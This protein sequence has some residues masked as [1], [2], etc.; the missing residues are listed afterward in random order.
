[1]RGAIACWPNQLFDEGVGTCTGWQNANTGGGMCPGF[2]EMMMMPD[3]KDG[4]A[5]PDRL[6]VS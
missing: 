2:D 4:N 1:M 5:N 3:A 6:F